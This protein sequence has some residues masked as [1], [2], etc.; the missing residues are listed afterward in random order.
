MSITLQYTVIVLLVVFS[1]IFVW[2]TRFPASWRRTRVAL[3]IPLLREGRPIWMRALGR[4]IAP[5]SALASGECG[6]CSGCK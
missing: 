5:A 6:G 2:R 1:A 4:W 3:A